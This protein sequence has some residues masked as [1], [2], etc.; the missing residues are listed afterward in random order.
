MGVHDWLGFLA[1]QGVKF[2]FLI[3][4]PYVGDYD[5]DIGAVWQRVD[6][7]VRRYADSVVAIEGTNEYDHPTISPN[8]IQPWDD[9][10]REY[11]Q[12]VGYVWRANGLGPDVPLLAPS[13]GTDAGPAALG[14]VG[15]YGC[16][17]RNAH[18][19]SGNK[20]YRAAWFDAEKE[21]LAPVVPTTAKTW[22]TEYG[23]TIT[24]PPPTAWNAIN[25]RDQ[26]VIN[27][28]QYLT[29]LD[30]P[31]FERAYVYSLFDSVG[32]IGMLRND[33]SP[34][35]AYTAFQR[36]L[37]L[38]DTAPGGAA[39]PELQMNLTGAP[40]D[41]KSEVFWRADGKYIVAFWREASLGVAPVTMSV[42]FPDK[43]SLVSYDLFTG[44]EEC[45][46]DDQEPGFNWTFVIGDDP[47]ILKV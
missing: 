44:A 18:A 40:A 25:E 23:S 39:P 13:F 19:Y 31:D 1:S 9:S 43:T 8:A 15:Q 6:T 45:P 34:R 26:G 22:V 14:D 10:L 2:D 7:I 29:L 46:K 28:K 21:H 32:G 12:E 36:L 35:P 20:V 11:M 3:G 16:D 4:K 30:D 17:R 37:G 47:I 5:A 27:V 24:Q 42:Q 41:L 38:A 33:L